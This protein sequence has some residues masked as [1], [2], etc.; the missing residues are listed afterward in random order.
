MILEDE[1]RRF[2]IRKTL[3]SIAYLQRFK[4][5]W[6]GAYL[7]IFKFKKENLENWTILVSKGKKITN[8]PEVVASEMGKINYV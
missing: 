1:E 2:K 6:M 5:L 3:N 8:I 7:L 4:D